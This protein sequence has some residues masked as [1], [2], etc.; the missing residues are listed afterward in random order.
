MGRA[1][2]PGP[3]DWCFGMALGQRLR[4]RTLDFAAEVARNYGDLTYFRLGPF[5]VYSVN[6]PA[7]VRLKMLKTQTR[8][9]HRCVRMNKESGSD[10]K[11]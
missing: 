7:L 4:T 1:Y 5:R 11:G 3:R 2:P 9:N 10:R 6:H 8:F